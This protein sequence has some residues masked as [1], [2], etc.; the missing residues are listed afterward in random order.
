MLSKG[1]IIASRV[2]ITPLILFMCVVS[3]QR[4]RRK[5]TTVCLTSLGLLGSAI[6]PVNVVTIKKLI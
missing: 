2:F 4:F 5:L 3:E 1:F 6:K